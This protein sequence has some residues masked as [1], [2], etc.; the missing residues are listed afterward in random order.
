ML[1]IVRGAGGLATA[2]HSHLTPKFLNFVFNLRS[3]FTIFT[4]LV[5]GWFCWCRVYFSK[6]MVTRGKHASEAGPRCNISGPLPR[7]VNNF[8]NVFI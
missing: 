2:M 3:F 1:N 8:R 6:F 7:L 4:Y 5:A